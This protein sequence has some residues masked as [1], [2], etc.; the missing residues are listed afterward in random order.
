M[1]TAPA[2]VGTAGDAGMELDGTGM[3]LGTGTEL[4]C[5]GAELG[6]TGTEFGT[7]ELAEDTAGPGTGGT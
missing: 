1:D 3:E 2:V 6:C 7:T 4:G 5:T